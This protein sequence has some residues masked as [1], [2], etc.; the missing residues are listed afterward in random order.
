METKTI[1]VNVQIQMDVNV[2]ENTLTQVQNTLEVMNNIISMSELEVQPQIF[3]S[4]I[5]ESDIINVESDG[6]TDVM[7]KENNIARIKQIIA[8]QGDF[9]IG[10]VDGFDSSPVIWSAG[11][12]Q[13]CADAF[14]KDGVDTTTYTDNV[15]IDNDFHWYEDLTVVQIA[16]ILNVCE[17]WDVQCDKTM[18]RCQD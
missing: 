10:Q 15:E 1:T 8:K 12:S 11:N 4:D 3:I 18:E 9:M 13:E 5:S 14:N 7:D 17:L 6:E 16:D 2:N